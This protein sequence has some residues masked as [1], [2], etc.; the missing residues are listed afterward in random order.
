MGCS[1]A[2]PGASAGT[3]VLA[4]CSWG[5]HSCALLQVMLPP[6][7]QHSD[8][9]GAQEMVLDDDECPLQIFREWP[10]DKG[11]L[12][13]EL[14][15]RWFASASG[16]SMAHRLFSLPDD[17]ANTCVLL[18]VFCLLPKAAELAQVSTLVFR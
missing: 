1:R 14:I 13:T 16:L 5:I 11:E 12:C 17:V 4:A 18:G 9:R 8:D 3:S 2:G 7:A 15:S 10:S 6:G